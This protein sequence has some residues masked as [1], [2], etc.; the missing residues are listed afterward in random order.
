M[1]NL[2]TNN[3]NQRSWD[4][5]IWNNCNSSIH[6]QTE[7]IKSITVKLGYRPQ[8]LDTSIETDIFEFT[9][10]QQ[11]TNS[12][13]LQMSA[14]LTRGAR[15][16]CLCGLRQ[17]HSSLLEQE[18]AQAIAQAFLGENFPPN[19]TPTGN[20]MTWIQDSIALAIQLQNILTDLAIP[21]YITG[22]VAAATYGEPR[23]TRDLDIVI[24]LLPPK[25]NSLVQRL[26]SE[27]FYVPN[28]E[29]VRSGRL[30]SL[31]ITHQETIARADL[32]LAGNS[33]FEQE[34]FKRR[35]GIAIPDRG[36]LYLAS[37]EDIIL[38]K[39]FWRNQTQ[40][41]KQWRDVLG[42]LKV[43]NQNLDFNYLNQQAI[44][45]GLTETLAQAMIEAGL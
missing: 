45:L 5:K 15:Q 27:G 44:G 33:N 6:T 12:D 11:R 39:L 2:E 36:T 18:F 7:R 19:F 23:T 24:A 43:Q 4:D 9:L 25:L 32:M 13:R 29:D 21:H 10:L 20:E 37:P 34:K 1:L 31:S 42:I 8:A 14:S 16:L 26:E 30:K 17:T 41:E 38:S 35:Q 28:V 22:G 40:S 3:K